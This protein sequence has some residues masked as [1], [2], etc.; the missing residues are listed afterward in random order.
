MFG[1]F[2]PKEKIWANISEFFLDIKK[3]NYLI[4]DDK[5]INILHFDNNFEKFTKI[6]DAQPSQ[7]KRSEREFMEGI[8]SS[9]L[10]C[11]NYSFLMKEDG[12]PRYIF[13]VGKAIVS[14]GTVVTVINALE[15]LRTY[16]HILQTVVLNYKTQ[17]DVEADFTT[18]KN[19]EDA[20]EAVQDYAE[21]YSMLKNAEETSFNMTLKRTNT[22]TFG[23]PH[24]ISNTYLF[25]GSVEGQ[26]DMQIR[27]KI[28][29][30]LDS[31]L[32][33]EFIDYKV[34]EID[35]YMDEE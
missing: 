2:K 7:W 4:T 19:A 22:N 12:I 26:G 29:G 17:K 21:L 25:S 11:V 28:D 24:V 8:H 13:K 30:M 3:N 9:R 18:N 31:A 23:S 5:I 6:L 10:D 20:I 33:I 27:F 15:A 1:F 14:T 34:N 32:T 16:A 35:P